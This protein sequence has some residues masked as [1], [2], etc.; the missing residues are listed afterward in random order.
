M[1]MNSKLASE[2]NYFLL[3]TA[4]LYSV[5]QSGVKIIG[6]A[7][8]EISEWISIPTTLTLALIS[9]KLAGKLKHIF[10]GNFPKA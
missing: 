2:S 5:M 6:T 10:I 3:T 1:V 9:S 4:G 8:A 7:V